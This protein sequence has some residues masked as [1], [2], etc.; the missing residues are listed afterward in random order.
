MRYV[1]LTAVLSLSSVLQ[2]CNGPGQIFAL[3]PSESGHHGRIQ[4]RLS[5]AGGHPAIEVRGFEP[6]SGFSDWASVLRVY[7]AVA[8]TE[9]EVP[10]ILGS[11]EWREEILLFRPRFPLTPG[12]RI[13]VTF[14][15]GAMGFDRSAEEPAVIRRYRIERSQFASKQRSGCVRHKNHPPIKRD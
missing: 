3:Q 15:P 12:L 8:D 6:P 10:S 9:E 2:S 13:R 14:D 11:Y 4:I 7:V 1:F 5:E